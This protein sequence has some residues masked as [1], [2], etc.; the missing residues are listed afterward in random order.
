MYAKDAMPAA[1]DAMSGVV[2]YGS[3]DEPAQI[4]KAT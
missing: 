3:D 2:F 1:V 4:D